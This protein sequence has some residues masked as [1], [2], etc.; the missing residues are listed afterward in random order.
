[1][2]TKSIK[3]EGIH[4][5]DPIPVYYVRS[6]GPYAEAAEASFGALMPFLYGNKL[7]NQDIRCFGISHDDP[8][9]T[10]AEKLRFDAAATVEVEHPVEGEVQ[11]KNIEGG[12]YASFLHKGAYENLGETY[13]TIFSQWLPDSG[14][15][16]RDAPVFEEYL[17]RDPRNT[18]P[19]N[20]RTLIYLPLQ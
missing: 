2:Q 16:L 9:V 5:L 11:R 1:M 8:N 12:R 15:Q 6:T 10:E 4:I 17:N 14:E 13:D 20:L 3:S 19:E 18:K 7:T